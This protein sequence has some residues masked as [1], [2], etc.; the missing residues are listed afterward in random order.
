MKKQ[1][2]HSPSASHTFF[3]QN[4][5]TLIIIGALIVILYIG[6]NVGIYMYSKTMKQ[7]SGGNLP[8]ST[9]TSALQTVTPTPTPAPLNSKGIYEFTV[10]TGG[11]K[12]GLITRGKLNPVDPPAGG[13]QEFDVTASKGAENLK[14]ILKTDTKEKTIP[15]TK[16]AA[17]PDVWRGSWTMDDTYFYV[18][19]VNVNGSLDGKEVNFPI[20]FR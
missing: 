13:K 19:T 20:T 8:G 11:G 4:K 1:S 9:V 16:D 17:K 15:L 5:T 2:A 3:N 18:Y 6:L 7:K 14:V 12:K 10:S